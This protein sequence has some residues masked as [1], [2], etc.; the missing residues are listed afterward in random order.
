MH[1]HR[2]PVTHPKAKPTAA[3]TQTA[4]KGVRY[5]IAFRVDSARKEATFSADGSFVEEE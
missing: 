4:G 5:E 1:A 3:S 2:A